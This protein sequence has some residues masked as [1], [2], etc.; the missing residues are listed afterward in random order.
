MPWGTTG[1]T[2]ADFAAELAE[3]GQRRSVRPLAHDDW[4]VTGNSKEGDSFEFYYVS[5]HD[6]RYEC[7][8]YSHAYGDVRRRR[9]CGHVRDTIIWRKAN[10]DTGRTKQLHQRDARSRRRNEG[11]ERDGA[12]TI[13]RGDGGGEDG[14]KGSAEDRGTTKEPGD[15]GHT[16]SSRD[17][18]DLL[19]RGHTQS[20][21]ASHRAGDIPSDPHDKALGDP[22]LPGQFATFRDHQ[23]PAVQ[24]ILEAYGQGKSVVFLDAPTG[25]GKTLIAEVVRRLSTGQPG[26][27][28]LYVCNNKSLQDQFAGDFPYAKVLKGRKNYPTLDRPELFPEVSAGDCSMTKITQLPGC[29]ACPNSRGIDDGGGSWGGMQA[30]EDLEIEVSHCDEC[31]GTYYPEVPLHQVCEYLIARNTAQHAP[32]AVLN[33]AYLLAAANGVDMFTG[34]DLVICDEADQLEG[35]LMRHVEVIIGRH[36]RDRLNISLPSQV[37]EMESWTNWLR[38]DVIIKVKHEITRLSSRDRKQRRRKKGLG[39]LLAKIKVILPKL[40]DDWIV[41]GYEDARRRRG[42]QQRQTVR[43]RPVHVRDHAREWLWDHGQKWLLMSATIISPAQMAEDLGLRDN[44]WAAVTVESAFPPERRPVFLDRHV[45][46]VIRKTEETVRPKLVAEIQ[47]IA[48]EWLDERILVHTH[49]YN[50]T[51]YLVRNLA[52]WRMKLAYQDSGSR[53]GM[54]ERWLDSPNGILLAPSFD[55][56]ID[57]Y[58]DRCRVQIIAK[59]PFPYLGDKQVSK[60]MHSPGGQLWYTVET[61]RSIVQATGRVMRSED[62]WG[63]CVSPTTLILRADLRWVLARTLQVGDQIIGFDD[64]IDRTSPENDGRRHSLRRWRIATVEATGEMRLP[65]YRIDLETGEVLFATADHRWICEEGQ[66]TNNRWIETAKLKPGYHLLRYFRPWIVRSDWDAG[67]LSGFF[68]GEGCL[69]IDQGSRNRLVTSIVAVQNPGIILDK[70]VMLLKKAGFETAVWPRA[71]GTSSIN[72]QGGFAEHLRFLGQIQPDRLTNKLIAS[73]LGQAM[74]RQQAVKIKKVEY[75]GYGPV[76]TLQSSTGTY[77]AEGFGS[78]N[79]YILDGS[80][81]R[82]LNENGQLFPSWWREAVVRG[83]DLQSRELRKG[84]ERART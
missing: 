62:D 1:T 8:C 77:V 68:D 72:I 22:P 24:D 2:E 7:S 13:E 71:T 79:T 34:R 58:D 80:V 9:I 25:S 51:D 50:L 30:V 43:F 23:L 56:G 49:S 46:P 26:Q 31:H 16:D 60:R 47:A 39:E 11:A 82:L 20:E 10:G 21:P 59:A 81:W 64:E 33:T 35:E 19:R 44:E 74:K 75:V 83:Q 36:L 70:A 53:E 32:L 66:Y 67:W 15:A 17:S 78:H 38:T 45:G 76:T 69:S 14:A 54:L 48:D 27:Q 40:D 4:E 18:S 41:D 61:I 37:T 42:S 5:L 12:A 3:R 29:S 6:E 73:G 63:A 57:L 65:R 52:P 28:T 55:R 84:F